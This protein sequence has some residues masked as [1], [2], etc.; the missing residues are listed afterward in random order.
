[1]YKVL[2]GKRN[3]TFRVLWMLE[4]IDEKYELIQTKPHSTELLAH[5]L[6]GKVPVLIDNA[7]SIS[8]SVAIMTYLADKHNKLTAPSGTIS[9][10]YQDSVTFCILDDLE[11]I[12]WVAAKNTFVLPENRRNPEIIPNL[13]WEFCKNLSTFSKKINNYNWV[14][15][16]NFSI[17]DIL[18]THC[19]NW[20]KRFDFNFENEKI[21]D[22]YVRALERPVYKKLN[23]EN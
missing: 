1:M 17:P 7:I 11:S 23:I 4:E 5:N 22:Y 15:G 6:N 20:A 10:A 9:R 2:G 18:L 14:G 3:R 21:E 8:D 13:K 12:L 19:L 16:E